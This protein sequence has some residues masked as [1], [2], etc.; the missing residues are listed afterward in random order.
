MV[1]LKAE[2]QSILSSVPKMGASPFENFPARVKPQVWMIVGVNGAG[3]TTT[4]G[5]LAHLAAQQGARVLVAAGDTFR[6]AAQSRLFALRAITIAAAFNSRLIWA[7]TACLFPT[8]T[9][10]PKRAKP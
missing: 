8:S 7:R 3:K 9:P 1:W 4:I 5:K 10:P 2:V 6:A